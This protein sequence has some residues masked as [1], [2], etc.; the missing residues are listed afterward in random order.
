VLLETLDNSSRPRCRAC[1]R[2]P[3]SRKWAAWRPCWAG[4]I[5]YIGVT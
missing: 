5:E 2:R 1:S 3:T 4:A